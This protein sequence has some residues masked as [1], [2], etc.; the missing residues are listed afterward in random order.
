MIRLIFKSMLALHVQREDFLCR[1]YV[2]CLELVSLTITSRCVLQQMCESLAGRSG[3]G[4]G[5]AVIRC[6]LAGQFLIVGL[7]VFWCSAGGVSSGASLGSQGAHI[8]L[9]SFCGRSCL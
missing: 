1:G 8:L 3:C 7:E 5:F 6:F 9:Q 2:G 4:G